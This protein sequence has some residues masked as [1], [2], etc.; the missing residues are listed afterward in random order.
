MALILNLTPEIEQYLTQRATEQGLSLESYTLKL[1]TDTILP[2]EKK[3]KLVNLLQSWIEEEDEQEQQET[4]EYLIE[5]LDQDRLSDRRLFP[6][7]LKGI[8]W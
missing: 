5:V 7:Q 3:I 1:L 2:Q 6:A 8:T 4:G